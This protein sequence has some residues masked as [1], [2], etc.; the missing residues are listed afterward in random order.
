M[1]DFFTSIQRDDHEV[2]DGDYV[3]AKGCRFRS[4]HFVELTNDWTLGTTAGLEIQ[5]VE[6]QFCKLAVVGHIYSCE[7]PL[8]SSQE[9]V[10]RLADEISVESLVTALLPLAGCYVVFASWNSQLIVFSDATALRK[11]HYCWDENTD[12][13]IVASS[14]DDIARCLSLDPL[15]GMSIDL[16]DYN[17]IGSAPYL[18][19]ELTA[20]SSIRYLVPCHFLDVDRMAQ[21]RFYPP[22]VD[23]QPS[24]DAVVQKFCK[25]LRG[26]AIA[27]ERAHGKCYVAMTAGI[28]SRT[29]LASFIAAGLSGS[30][31]AF[32]FQYPYLTDSDPDIL[33]AQEVC[34]SVSVKHQLLE[35]KTANKAGEYFLAA[36]DGVMVNSNIAD[37]YR[38]YYR[39]PKWACTP[40]FMLSH[41]NIPVNQATLDTMEAWFENIDDLLGYDWLDFFYWEHRLSRWAAEGFSGS[42]I[43]VPKV[44]I[45]NSLMLYHLSFQVPF[46]KRRSTEFSR[47]VLENLCPGIS[48]IPINP[49]HGLGN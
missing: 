35:I 25:I 45:F 46:V 11:V 8:L 15:D 39:L 19:G 22:A 12:A 9:V 17:V 20:Y 3:L 38:V 29:T 7:E 23:E 13:L 1:I 6:N 41:E 18:P 33:V 43:S 5:F 16:G 31:G 32:T 36:C 24:Y 34:R 26:S 2:I 48:E 42:E 27:T 28:D 4:E 44:N 14:I 21:I 30:L 37:I 10:S 40:R 47:D 49:R